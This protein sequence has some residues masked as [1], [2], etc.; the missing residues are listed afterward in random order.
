[1]LEKLPAR[2]GV[3]WVRQGFGLFRKQPGALL[4]VFFSSLFLTMASL[5]V[6]LLGTLLPTMLT[7]LF[8]IAL[9][10]ACA[11][12]DQ[13]KR[14]MPG[15]V[16]TGFRKPARSHLLLLGVLYIF[17]WLVAL[18]VLSWMDN[19]VFVKMVLRQIPMDDKLLEGSRGAILT[20]SGIYLVAWLLTCFAAPLIYWQR[21][22]LGKALFFSAYAVLRS[23]WA[24]LV[25]GITL[26][27]LQQICVSI[28]LLLIDSAALEATILL[29]VFI[30]TVI[31][32]H[33]MLYASYCRIFGTPPA[34]PEPEPKT[35]V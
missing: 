19:G 3:L 33:C 10:Q 21:Q 8:S 34:Q 7:P 32:V 13:G 18:A 35:A 31:V 25:G 11:E 2:M 15:L 6:P 27:A 29:A 9:L 17:V 30:T 1:M 23:F 4:A 20:A 28:P 22:S 24:F 5:V 26:F 14:P 16:F 12:V